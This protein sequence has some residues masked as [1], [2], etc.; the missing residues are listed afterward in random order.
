MRETAMKLAVQLVSTKKYEGA[1][2]FALANDIFLWMQEDSKLQPLPSDSFEI[3]SPDYLKHLV[4][5]NGGIPIEKIIEP[6]K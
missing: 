2:V 5:P 1:D 4:V 6:N 3:T